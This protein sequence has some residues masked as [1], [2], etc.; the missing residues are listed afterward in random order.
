MLAQFGVFLVGSGYCLQALQ[1]PF[2]SG[3]SGR[4]D[5]ERYSPRVLLVDSI[6][7]SNGVGV[8]CSLRQDVLLWW[9]VMDLI[10]SI[11]RSIGV[12]ACW[13]D[14]W[15][16]NDGQ[17]LLFRVGHWPLD[18]HSWVHQRW[19]SRFY[20]WW[21][22]WNRVSNQHALSNSWKDERFLNLAPWELLLFLDFLLSRIDYPEV[23]VLFHPVS[24][25]LWKPKITART[26]LLTGLKRTDDTYKSIN[27][28]KV[29][30]G[31]VIQLEL[32][33]ELFG[34]QR[35]RFFVRR[36]ADIRSFSCFLGLHGPHQAFE[37]CISVV[38]DLSCIWLINI[39]ELE[40]VWVTMAA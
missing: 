15:P 18:L 4:V 30:W 33:L 26:G 5:A 29:A 39:I 1:W 31:L 9:V 22:I 19:L 40:G 17:P 25:K 2:P 37:R 3:S 38:L 21:N 8:Q 13:H 6:G 7:I 24:R 36:L 28:G 35:S 27:I 20:P 16:L 11:S 23:G 12:G 34:R 10:N 32:S 14:A